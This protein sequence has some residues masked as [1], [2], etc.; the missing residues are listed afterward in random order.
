MVG[1]GTFT[2][3]SGHVVPR[4]SSR[5]TINGRFLTQPTTG[6][7]RYAR[8]I[9]L[10]MDHILGAEPAIAQRLALRV[11]APP[12]QR[13]FYPALPYSA[14][15]HH[16]GRRPRLG[17]VRA[18]CRRTGQKILNLCN[19]A[20]VLAFGHITCI[21]DLNPWLAPESYG[22]RFR[23]AYRSLIPLIARTAGAIVTV[24]EFSARQLVE[25]GLCPRERIT[26]APNGHEHALR[27]DP[28]RA[29]PAL[30]QGLTRPFVSD[31]G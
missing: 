23:A 4:R 29:D 5:W 24:S 6:V 27:W 31:A 13:R 26:I 21:H 9:L 3:S 10:E 8:E 25:H 20:P 22:W 17:S 18:P 19:M 30:L 16:P 2:M 11:I 1:F 14:R 12:P 7:Q 15:G 28:G